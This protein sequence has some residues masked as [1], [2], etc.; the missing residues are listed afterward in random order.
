MVFLEELPSS[1]PLTKYPERIDKNFLRNFQQRIWIPISDHQQKADILALYLRYYHCN[2]SA[3]TIALLYNF[4]QL[5]NFA[6]N[7]SRAIVDTAAMLPSALLGRLKW[8]QADGGE[9]QRM[10]ALH[11]GL[12]FLWL[13]MHGDA[14]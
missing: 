3:G 10:N 4:P 12:T 14:F 9:E 8:V 5:A 13:L 11:H 2:L 7:N 1:K 6:Q